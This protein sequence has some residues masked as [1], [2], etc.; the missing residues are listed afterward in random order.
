MPREI[1]AGIIIYRRT[2]EGPKFLL[3]YH[4]GRYW[5]FPK[6]KIEAKLDSG[7]E[8]P[9]KKET[10]FKAALREV[11][12]ETGLASK[13]LKLQERFK[14]YDR[15]IYTRDKKKIFKIVIYYLAESHKR[16]IKI[17]NEHEGY[18][19]FLHRD[20]QKILIH[21]NLKDN[22]KNAYDIIREKSLPRHK[23]AIKKGDNAHRRSRE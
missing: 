21:K 1:S 16:E 9:P 7:K 19:W 11:R 18:G 13:N 10:A 5:S 15:Y 2:K 4:G 22:L 14:K 20:A 12:E 23:T 6:G 17:S 8:E 3:L